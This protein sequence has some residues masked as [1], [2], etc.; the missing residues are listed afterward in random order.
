MLT[1]G[2]VRGTVAGARN[3]ELGC[4]HSG[5]GGNGSRAAQGTAAAVTLGLRA[6]LRWEL[7]ARLGGGE[8]EVA[9]WI[10]PPRLI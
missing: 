6:R 3:S 10:P 1:E 7:R 9:F 5:H 2:S 4:R 8:C